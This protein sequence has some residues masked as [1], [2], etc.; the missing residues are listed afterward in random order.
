MP[1]SEAVRI[2]KKSAEILL[3]FLLGTGIMYWMYRDTDW[4]QF[5]GTLLHMDWWWMLLSFVFGISAQVFRGLRWRLALAPLGERPR[6]ASCV[7]SIYVSYAASL[8]IPRVGEVTRCGMLKRSDGV[9]FAKSLGTVV[10]E[11]VVDSVVMLAVCGITFLA[12]LPVLRVFLNATGT[13]IDGVVYR[14][15]TMGYVVTAICVVAIAILASCLLMRFS[16]F[17]GVRDKLRGVYEGIASVTK[18]QR[19]GLYAF[20]SVAIWASYFLHFYIAFFCF[21]FTAELSPLAA[22]CIFCIGT[23]AVLVPTP[24]GAGP[25]HFA[26][27]T[28]LVMYG[29]AAHSAIL[30]ALV[31]HTLHTGLVILLGLYGW[32][33]L[34]M[35]PKINVNNQ[36]TDK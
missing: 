34:S 18:L 19:R 28:M 24:N 7:E 26:V 16:V 32:V 13:T 25:W 5:T 36:S 9:S 3:P 20:Y 35:R 15:T 6:V 30:F 1:K 27:K 29:V 8:V 31:V 22:L 23:F 33:G 17:A 12:Q 2:I 21:P 10:T 4:S 11:R 14:F